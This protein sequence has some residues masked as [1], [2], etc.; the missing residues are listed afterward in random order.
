MNGLRHSLN[1]LVLGSSPSRGTNP[2]PIHSQWVPA[3]KSAEI[4]TIS[5]VMEAHGDKMATT[6]ADLSNPFSALQLPSVA[7]TANPPPRPNSARPACPSIAVTQAGESASPSPIT[8]MA[9]A[10]GSS[11][12]LWRRPKR[13]AC[14]WRS[15]SKPGCSTSPTSVRTAEDTAALLEFLS[16]PVKHM[17][18]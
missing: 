11:S 13:K 16:K 3:E 2:Q 15:E 4:D 12:P 9:S 14:S 5:S 17:S 7:S 6:Q 10:C 18:L 8:G 1:Q